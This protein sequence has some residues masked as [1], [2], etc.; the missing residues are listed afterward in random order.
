MLGVSV[1][2]ELTILLSLVTLFGI[3]LFAFGWWKS[4]QLRKAEDRNGVLGAHL[5]KATDREG[6]LARN[7]LII[8]VLGGIALIL[9]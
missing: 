2:Q 9:L 8:F 7:G 4:A 3:F 5:W 1:P 6:R